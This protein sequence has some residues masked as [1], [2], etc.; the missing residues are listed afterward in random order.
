MAE[1]RTRKIKPTSQGELLMLQVYEQAYVGYE[2]DEATPELSPHHPVHVLTRAEMNDADRVRLWQPRNFLAKVIEEPVGYL[3][4]AQP[5]LN[6]LRR[7]DQG[8]YEELDVDNEADKLL[9]SKIDDFY[10]EK[11]RPRQADLVLW[12]GQYG[13][14]F[15]K[16]TFDPGVW[17]HKDAEGEI[18]QYQG[19]PG[20]HV[21]AYP[22]MEGA[23]ERA[24]A[25]HDSEDPDLV[26]SAV[27]YWFERDEDAWDEER[28]QKRA[29]LLYPDRI[30][31][32]KLTGSGWILD[33]ERG[34]TGTGIDPH[35]WGVTPMA[36]CWNNGKPDVH[37]GLE[38]QKVLNKD[39]YD[40]NVAMQQVAFPQ[41][42]RKGL[43]PPG[44]W[45]R[46][47][48]T[49]Q[50]EV[51]EPLRSGPHVVWDVPVDGEVGQLPADMGTFPLAKY[52][53][54]IEDLATLTRSVAVAKMKTSGEISGQS[55]E[56]DSA[57]LLLP[58][59]RAKAEGLGA[60]IRDIYR[61]VFAMAQRDSTVKALLGIDEASDLI[62]QVQFDLN[63]D[64]DDHQE[65]V[66]DME[67][68]RAGNMSLVTYLQR[69][70]FTESEAQKEIQ[71]LEEERAQKMEEQAEA[72]KAMDPYGAG[73]GGGEG[74]F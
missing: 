54:D 9:Q 14:S 11:I 39:V 72:A 12:Q 38:T 71:R 22:R 35:P 60:C 33:A 44:G 49:G 18:V 24:N 13:R 29:Q 1:E 51:V 55:K 23:V 36:V 40:L 52:V 37:D 69:R 31:W 68:R 63:L 56:M 58:R 62:V 73:G 65:S 26:T 67:D 27:V 20:L 30:E 57:Q 53:G 21:V 4:L 6:V 19:E 42:W 70:G 5:R 28:E 2:S 66:L 8:V 3:G 7:V 47:P 32:L 34:I 16:V 59:L 41:R 15:A 10:Q 25:W 61:I 45:A 50:R 46:N 43:I 74:S 17:L 64:K 48:L